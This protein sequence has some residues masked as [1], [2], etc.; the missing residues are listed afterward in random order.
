[1]R[2]ELTPHDLIEQCRLI[3]PKNSPEAKIPLKDAYGESSIP[4]LVSIIPHE[5]CCI[6][7]NY[8]ILSSLED[9]NSID[10]EYED[11]GEDIYKVG[12]LKGFRTCKIIVDND[13]EGLVIVSKKEC[14]SRLTYNPKEAGFNVISNYII[15]LDKYIFK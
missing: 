4:M 11:L 1:M 5:I 2:F 9:T 8:Q 13:L 15:H 10:T 6:V 14:K 12:Y 3:N 7:V